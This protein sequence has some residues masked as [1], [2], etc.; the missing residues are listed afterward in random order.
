MFCP[1][2][3]K[4]LADG[5]K[6]CT[7]CGY[8]IP[9]ERNSAVSKNNTYKNKKLTAVIA[10]VAAVVMLVVVLLGKS[11]KSSSDSFGFDTCDAAVNSYVMAVINRDKEKFVSC[12][13]SDQREHVE[14]EIIAWRK[15]LETDMPDLT[16]NYQFLLVPDYYEIKCTIGDMESLTEDELDHF[17]NNGYGYTVKE[18]YKVLINVAQS[19]SDNVLGGTM[20]YGRE[21]VPLYVGKIGKK[22]YVLEV[23]PHFWRMG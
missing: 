11:G 12:F 17:S 22:W 19:K 18:G 6:F 20:T 21:D 10:A 14:K 15:S 16:S 7:A 3:G 23:M 4:E 2:C 1:K 9:E 8:R 13:Q 5:M